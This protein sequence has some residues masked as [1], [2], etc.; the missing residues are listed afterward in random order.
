MNA[1][2]RLVGRLQAG[3]ET[4]AQ[5]LFPLVYD[6]LRGLAASYMRGERADHTLQ[7]TALVNEAFV[8]L[9]GAREAGPVEGRE[10]FFRV[11]AKAM[12]GILVDHAR[13]KGAEKRGAGADRVTLSEAVVEL[14]DSAMRLLDVDAAIAALAEV[15]VEL[16]RIVELRFFGG[17]TCEEAA[18]ALGLPL[19]TVERGWRT[20]R[21]WL[22]RRLS[23]HG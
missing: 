10:H 12:R 17:L 23:A 20:A 18:R 16:S 2:T 13:A 6:E 9:A 4:A 15:D 21:A 5:D 3:D 11:A 19:R 14:G 8:R 1:V 7:S 22:Q